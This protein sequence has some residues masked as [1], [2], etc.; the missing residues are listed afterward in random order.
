M[1]RKIRPKIYNATDFNIRLKPYQHFT[2]KNGVPVYT[3]H[4][5]K[6]EVL[7]IELVFFAGNWFEDKNLLAASTNFL[8]KN[9]TKQKSAFELN[10][11]FE[12]YGSF[13]ERRCYNETATLSLHCLTKHTETLLPVVAEI[14]TESVFQQEELDIYRKN[15]KQK[16]KVNLTKAEFVANRIIDK[17]IYGFHH[18]YGKYTTNEAFDAV[19][20][21]DIIDYY[22]QYYATG[23]C[24]LFVSGYL[25]NHLEQMLNSTVGELPFRISDHKKIDFNCE[26]KPST[27]KRET[28]INDEN[29][30]Q[31]SLRIARHFPNRR[32]EDYTKAQVMNTVFGG[33]F[34]SRLMS[35]IREEKGYTYGISSYIQNHIQDTALIISTEA[36]RNVID[37]TIEEVWKEAKKLIEQPVGDEELLMVKNY[38]IGTT[39]GELD[40]PFEIMN[41]WK[42]YILNNLDDDYFYR[43][44]DTIKQITATDIQ[45]MAEKYLKK[46]DFRQLVVY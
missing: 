46:E 38:L 44:M 37:A 35:N 45:E 32:Q 18:P 14:L 21:E 16:L 5:G 1:D 17:N 43:T 30:V 24:L 6:E 15:A 28:I 10:E 4:A 26:V 22:N 29:A 25:P 41:R 42:N 13:L 9:G 3:I 31:G 39:L 7:S 12:Y 40:G 19:T 33:Y 34:S 8:L 36:G 27:E 20:R 2:L 23:N 11:F